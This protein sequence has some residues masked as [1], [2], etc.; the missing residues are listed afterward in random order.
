[1]E[2]SRILMWLAGIPGLIWLAQHF[3]NGGGL[4]LNAVNFIFPFWTLRGTVVAY[5]A[6]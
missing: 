3:I 1:M 2:N 5:A 6:F 4:N